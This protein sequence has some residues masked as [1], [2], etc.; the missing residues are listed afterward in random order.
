MG[1]HGP[2]SDPA[3]TGDRTHHNDDLFIRPALPSRAKLPSSAKYAEAFVL[4]R[5]PPTP[6]PGA[7]FVGISLR[8]F[9]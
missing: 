8:P 2:E 6:R 1:K 9:H 3:N 4:V 5:S 7:R